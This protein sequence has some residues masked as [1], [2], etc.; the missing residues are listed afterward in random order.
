LNKGG[1]LILINSVLSA[2]PIY[3]A[4]F[5]L[6]PR[7]VTEQ[8]A[9]LIRDFLWQGGK[10]NE[11]KIHLV[12]WEIVKKSK[13]DGGLQIRDPAL[14]NLSFGGKILWKLVSEPAHPVSLTLSSKYGVNKNLSNLQKDSPTNSTQI[15]KLCCK[16]S[17]FFKNQSIEYLEM[18]RA[19]PCGRTA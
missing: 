16:S 10:G 18:A 6:A 7:S 12:N 4:T 14:V 3:Q 2:I 5:I 17:C 8:I 19:R 9:K 13:A 15:W 11:K 1:K